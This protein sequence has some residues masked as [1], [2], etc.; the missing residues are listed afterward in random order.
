MSLPSSWAAAARMTRPTNCLIAAASVLVGAVLAGGALRGNAVLAAALGFLVCAG[1]YALNDFFDV[2][3][4]RMVKPWRP[5]ASGALGARTALVITLVCWGAAGVLAVL[6]G[7]ICFGF[8]LAWSAV[9]WLYSWRAKGWGLAGHVVVSGVASS[10]FLLGA[11]VAGSVRAGIAPAAV[12]AALHLARE[13]AK[14]VA[15]ARGDDDVGVRTLAVRVGGRRALLA[16]LGCI[17]GTVGLSLVPYVAAGYG[18]GYL[19]VMVVGA[20]PLLGVCVHRI[21]RGARGEGNEIEKAGAAVSRL[22]KAAMPVG[23]AAFLAAGI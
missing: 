8:W 1:G 15:D 14:G 6:G 21:L 3:A 5:L 23:L 22:L 7:W 9:L 4:D 17:A 2:A 10:G 11:A 20:Y 12:A 18:P 13:I 16:S 19:V